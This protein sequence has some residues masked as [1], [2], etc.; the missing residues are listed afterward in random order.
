VIETGS[1]R[2]E[3]IVK[4]KTAG[5][6]KCKHCGYEKAEGERHSHCNECGCLIRRGRTQHKADCS[7]LELDQSYWCPSCKRFL[8]A[9]AFCPEH[10]NPVS[11]AA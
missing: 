3:V 5:P 11:H 2:L 10:G 6:K 8:A 4:K 1:V 9:G 7:R